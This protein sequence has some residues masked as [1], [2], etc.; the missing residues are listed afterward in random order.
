M[1]I[2]E[3]GT[4]FDGELFAAITALKELAVCE[5]IR[6]YAAAVRAVAVHAIFTPTLGFQK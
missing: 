5:L 2:A 4:N 6:F 3:H 1:A